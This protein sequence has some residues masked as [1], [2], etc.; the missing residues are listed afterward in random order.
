MTRRRG[1]VLLSAVAVALVVALPLVPG[2]VGGHASAGALRIP[3]EAL[4]VVV[5]ATV[6]PWRWSRIALSV[7]F[8]IALTLA[9]A[10]AVLDAIFETIVDRPFDPVGDLGELVAGAGVVQDSIGATGVVLALVAIGVVAVGVGAAGAWAALRAA[11]VVRSAGPRGR[12][13]VA[14]LAAVWMVCAVIPAAGPARAGRAVAASDDVSLLSATATDAAD[15]VAAQVRVQRQ[16]ADDPLSGRPAAQL[17]SGLAGHDVLVLFVESYGK[18]AVQGSS[19]APGVQSVLRAGRA[20]LDAEGYHSESAFLT[21]PTFGGISWLAHSTLQ[22]GVWVD[23]PRAYDE[24]TS[25]HRLTLAAAFRSAG[26]RTVSDI[27]SNAAPWPV[28]STFYRYESQL[29]GLDVGYLGPRFG[30]ARI[31]DEYTLKYFADHELTGPHTPVMAEID[32]VSSHTPWTPLPHLVPWDEVGDGSAFDGQPAE[33]ETADV[34]WR[35]PAN[36]QALYGQSVQFSLNSVF[37]FLREVDDPGLVV[38]M[39]GD[40][41]PARIVSGAGADHDVP[42]TILTK[43]AGIMSRISSWGWQPGTLPT[44]AA[45]VWRMDAFRDRFFTAF[46]DTAP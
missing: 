22:S 27:P 16:I 45:P 43:D 4:V 33:G 34:A 25:S 30:Y 20:Q 24:V 41:Q 5:L 40:H 14:A 42:V 35:D 17:L 37:A 15:A 39:L 19:F 3:V 44:S 7:V 21:S 31:P 36:V 23:S 32:L 46:G 28:G 13:V 29:N 6:L 12:T 26:W 18:V 2:I 8:A 9:I 38:V 1:S 11:A 10:L